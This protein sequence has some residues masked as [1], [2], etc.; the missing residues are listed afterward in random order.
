ML[1]YSFTHSFVMNNVN[2]ESAIRQILRNE[3]T[4]PEFMVAADIMRSMV[5]LYGSGWESD[6]LDVIAGLWTVKNLSM[7]MIGELQS[8]FRDGVKILEDLG[9]ITVETS[10]RSY[11]DESKPFE[12]KFYKAQDLM[13]LMRLFV[14]DR[15]IDKYRFEVSG[16]VTPRKE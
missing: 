12:E 10:L 14:A 8:K 7:E 1:E 3:N 13:T 16:W 6:V 5:I 2:R 15:Y 4:S 9:I 11:L